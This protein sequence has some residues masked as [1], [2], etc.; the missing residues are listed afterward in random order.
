MNRT[1]PISTLYFNDSELMTLN[2]TFLR[3]LFE[4]H[5]LGPAARSDILTFGLVVLYVPTFLSGLIGN[6]L[7]CLI[8]LSR[9]RFRNITN[10]FLCNLTIADLAG[11]FLRSFI[12]K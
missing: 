5:I 12:K 6:G 7:L 3:S 2:E 10:L 4:S 1:S 8:I 9:R 11:T